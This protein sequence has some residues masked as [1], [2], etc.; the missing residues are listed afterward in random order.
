MIGFKDFEELVREK[1]VM[2]Y[3]P[4]KTPGKPFKILK[5]AHT[6]VYGRQK[7]MIEKENI[8][9]DRH[10]KSVLKFL[11]NG[12]KITPYTETIRIMRMANKDIFQ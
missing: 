3:N 2:T 7:E 6:A 1:T 11:Q 10:P 5:K 4:Q 9:G 12:D 8:T